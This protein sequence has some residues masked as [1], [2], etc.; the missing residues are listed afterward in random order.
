MK[1]EKDEEKKKDVDLLSCKL[2][3]LLP[4]SPTVRIHVQEMRGR[5]SFLEE[6]N[7]GWIQ[8]MFSI[9]V[10]TLP[11]LFPSIDVSQEMSRRDSVLVSGKVLTL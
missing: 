2:P 6:A 10:R 11:D 8:M 4:P 9:T 7:D 3:S 1:T 5:D